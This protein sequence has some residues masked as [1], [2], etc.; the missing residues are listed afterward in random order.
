MPYQPVEIECDIN[1]AMKDKPRWEELCKQAAVEQDSKKFMELIQE[2]NRLLEEKEQRLR[3]QKA[4][5]SIRECPADDKHGAVALGRRHG[6]N[7]SSL[8]ESDG[9][10]ASW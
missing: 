7:A 9:W 1:P 2:I 10:L 4:S 5:E 6:S 8:R 3:N